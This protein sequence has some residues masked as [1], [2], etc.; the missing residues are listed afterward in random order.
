MG[1][2]DLLRKVAKAYNNLDYTEIEAIASDN[3]VYE[4][5][6]VLSSLNGKEK[7]ID[8]LKGKFETINET[9]NFAYAEIGILGS[10]RN[11]NVQVWLAP[12]S[13]CIILSQGSIEN[14]LALVFIKIENEKLSRI[15]ICT[16]AP[17]WSQVKGTREFPK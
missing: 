1:E 7:V 9:E 13:P 10:Q 6:E 12:G 15:D 14:K 5:Q 17:H 16:I 4:S 2:L 8:H 3:L 11:S